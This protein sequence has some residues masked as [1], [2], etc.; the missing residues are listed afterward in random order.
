MFGKKTEKGPSA[1]DQ[2]LSSLEM[3]M[4]VVETLL[5]KNDANLENIVE[6]FNVKMDIQAKQN[7]EKLLEMSENIKILATEMHRLR[8]GPY[9][10]LYCIIYIWVFCQMLEIWRKKSIKRTRKSMS[11]LS[12]LNSTLRRS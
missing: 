11:E 5:E 10:S 4:N 7:E 6:A 1:S 9:F 12:K 8:S 3:K 2:L